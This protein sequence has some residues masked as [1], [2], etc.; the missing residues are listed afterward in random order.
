MPLGGKTVLVRVNAVGTEYFDAD[1]EAIVGPRLYIINLP[2][3]EDPAAVVE[4]AN[5][6][7]RLEDRDEGRIGLLVNIETPKALRRVA[8]LAAAHKRVVGLQI[9]Y[10]DLLEPTGISRADQA[11]LAHVRLAV[12]LAAAETG[13]AAYDGAFAGVADLEGF[14]AECEAARRHGFAGKSCIH[15]KQIP[16]ANA[17]FQPTLA[18]IAWARRVVAVA[19]EAEARGVGAVLVDGRMIDPPFVTGARAV[20]A[21]A[22]LAANATSQTTISKPEA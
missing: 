16:I 17:A 7:E 18:E 3:V 8:E 21:L 11:A 14:R 4:A 6:L 1:M 9:G 2:M 12:R 20:V 22:D 15:P 10:A 5:L 19:A 13:A